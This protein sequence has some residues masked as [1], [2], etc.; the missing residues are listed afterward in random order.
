MAACET[1][2]LAPV[3]ASAKPGR[4]PAGTEFRELDRTH[5]SSGPNE[6]D[7]SVCVCVGAQNERGSVLRARSKEKKSKE[8]VK[9]ESRTVND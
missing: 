6:S 4:P 7:E 5:K 1:S 8:E 3:P 2:R 9:V